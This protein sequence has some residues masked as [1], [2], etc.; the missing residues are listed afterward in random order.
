MPGRSEPLEDRRITGCSRVIKL[1][2]ASVLKLECA[3]VGGQNGRFELTPATGLLENG[4]HDETP[5]P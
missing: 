4:S 5:I 3:P 1:G 2:V